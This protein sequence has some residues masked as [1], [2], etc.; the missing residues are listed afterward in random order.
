MQV[1]YRNVACR[2]VR[3]DD[4]EQDWL[5]A[6]LTFRT[7]GATGGVITSAGLIFA[8]S[9]FGLTFS[10]LNAAIQIG[11]IIGVGLLL[12]TFVVRTVTVPAIAVLV[13]KAS[14]WPG[15]P[16]VAR[17]A[18]VSSPKPTADVSA[19]AGSD[20]DAADQAADD[21]ESR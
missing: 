7:V 13:G 12:D 21:D 17:G 8:A 19:A 18:A 20:D 9:M 3:A 4:Y 5:R 14:W 10:S 1:E 6:L 16:E 2:I 11:F 15:R